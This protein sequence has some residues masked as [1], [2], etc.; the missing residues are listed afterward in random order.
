MAL[1]LK[2]Y[3]ISIKFDVN[4]TPL[5]QINGVVNDIASKASAAGG[6]VE[7][8]VTNTLSN[9]NKSAGGA[10]G[11]LGGYLKGIAGLFAGHEM[12]KAADEYSKAL[13]RI[14]LYAADTQQALDKVYSNAQRSGTSFVSQAELVGSVMQNQKH[15]GLDESQSIQL[16]DTF[17]KALSM[18]SQGA[19]QDNAALLQFVQMMGAEKVTNMDL[20]PL[21]HDSAAISKYMTEISGMS[22]TALMELAGK[23]SLSPKQVIGWLMEATDRV[24]DDFE[25]MPKTFGQGFQR[26]NNAVVK[27]VGELNQASGISTAL[28][29]IVGKIVDNF[30]RIVR[31]AALLVASW[32]LQLFFMRQG[33]AQS[34]AMAM[35]EGVRARFTKESLVASAK[36]VAGF[37]KMA[38]LLYGVYL[39]AEDLYYWWTGGQ[40]FA[41]RF[42]GDPNEWRKKT[43]SIKSIFAEWFGWLDKRGG[44]GEFLKKWGTVGVLVYTLLKLS[45]TLR[46]VRMLWRLAFSGG[47]VRAASGGVRLLVRALMG[48]R[49]LLMPVLGLFRLFGGVIGKVAL[50]ASRVLVAALMGV[51]RA[52]TAA[53][54]PLLANPITWIILAIAAALAAV[55][56]YWDDI[57]KATLAAWE[58]TTTAW[59]E[60]SAW[61][62]AIWDEAV[63]SVTAKWEGFKA[64]A[65]LLGETLKAIFKGYID[66]I[67]MFFQNLPDRIKGWIAQ[68][69]TYIADKAS[70]WAAML[71]PANWFGGDTPDTTAAKIAG[72][73]TSTTSTSNNWNPTLN[74]NV[75]I[76]GAA[77]PTA[78][79]RAVMGA[80]RSGWNATY[81]GL[82]NAEATY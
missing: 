37:A 53:L 19:A 13:G 56:Y 78:T 2:N 74:Q 18:T 35:W 52:A 58:A 38:A 17:G 77:T 11:A 32:R 43:E 48:L 45:G 69:G 79:G 9:V 75:I 59:G 31:L 12:I 51:A 68:I 23:G 70:E 64:S 36:Q 30:G 3:T 41:G 15:I 24:N 7:K 33:V 71:N 14:K 34:K 76:S 28:Y 10:L 57:K 8:S 67:A 73:N 42:L 63:K 60:F 65:S 46:L 81:P 66:D 61:F 39:I 82:P 22:A 25:K 62:G 55:W 29:R 54:A 50:V 16:A 1:S 40:S 27:F 49:G 4:K 5:A 21:L 26:I 44:P 80:T 20:K 6:K 47:G 72:N